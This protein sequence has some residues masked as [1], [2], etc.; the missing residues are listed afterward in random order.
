LSDAELPKPQ[1][2]FKASLLDNEAVLI[3]ACP[4][5]CAW[6]ESMGKHCIKPTDL[7]WVGKMG[8]ELAIVEG[9]VN[10]VRKELGKDKITSQGVIVKFDALD[11]FKRG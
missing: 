4:H 8:I 5:A 6:I 10:S 2:K 11:N 1:M 7:H 9:K 3:G